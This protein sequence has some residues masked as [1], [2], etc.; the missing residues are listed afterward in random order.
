[1]EG[2]WRTVLKKR[3]PGL[4]LLVVDVGPLSVRPI[5]VL[6]DLGV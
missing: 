2:G 1:M 4:P 5:V 3:E 6:P